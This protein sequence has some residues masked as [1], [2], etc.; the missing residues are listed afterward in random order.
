MADVVIVGAGH[1]GLVAAFYLAR[2]G[3]DVQVLEAKSI[4][5][6]ACITEELIP[7]FRF[8]TCANVVCWLRPEVV[9]DLGLDRRGLEYSSPGERIY[10]CFEVMTQLYSPDH[11]VSWWGDSDKMHETIAAISPRD[12]VAWEDWK[13]FWADAGR[14]FGPFVMRRPP[15]FDE[16]VAKAAELRLSDVLAAV[17][18]TSI[19]QFA[20]EFFESFE[21]R[22]HIRAPIDIGSAEDTGT[23]LL[24]AIAEAVAEYS[25]G[26]ARPPRG[27]VKGGMGRL[28]EAMADAAREQGATIRTSAP[29]KRIVIEDGRVAGVALESGDRIEAHVVISNAD[30]K[31]TFLQLIDAADVSPN[32]IRRIRALE[33]RIA[34]LKFHCALSG[35]P[36]FRAL[37]GSTVPAQ[38]SLLIHPGRQYWEKA[39]DDAKYGRLPEAPFM[40]MFTPSFWDDTLAPPGK[41]TVSFWIQFAPVKLA[42]GSWATSREEMADRLVGLVDRYAPNFSQLLIDRVLLTPADLE[43]RELLTDGNIHHVDFTPRQA[44]WRRPLEELASYSTPIEGLYLCGAGMHPYGEVTGAPGH[45]AAAAVLAAI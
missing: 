45:N 30:P 5:G 14:I 19:A 41:H 10:H 42:H 20:D 24:G 12:A 22:N 25:E 15:T 16:V 7:N 32:L 39:W 6:G 13:R 43:E 38:G 40:E 44:L 36:E 18:T 29:V 28:S 31:R 23:G 26:G 21:L 17:L 27:Y 34:P 2:A 33:T 1:N 9:V 3:L 37:P 35:L 8:S 11:A 4:V